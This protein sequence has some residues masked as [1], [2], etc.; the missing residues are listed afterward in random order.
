MNATTPKSRFLI[1]KL[2]IGLALLSAIAT[3]MM[4]AKL[5]QQQC[6]TV[7]VPIDIKISLGQG[8][9]RFSDHS[10]TPQRN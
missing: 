1:V 2:A 9:P 10:T 7:I 8:C 5:R 4:A 3:V 6:I